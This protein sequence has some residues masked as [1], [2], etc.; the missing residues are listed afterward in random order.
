MSYVL[1]DGKEV[2]AYPLDR[3]AVRALNPA[4]SLPASLSDEMLTGFGMFLVSEATPPQITAAQALR[5]IAPIKTKD[6][7]QQQWTIDDLSADQ[8]AAKLAAAKA[9][10]W[11]QV[12][13]ERAKAIEAGCTFPGIGVFQ[14]DAAS[15]ASLTEGVAGALLAAVTSQPFTV[16]WTLADN[17]IAKLNGQQMLL[18]GKVI[19]ERKSACHARSHALR[20]EIETSKDFASLMAIKVKDGWPA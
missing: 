17:T 11:D 12:K 3:E 10:V 8:V 13:A 1:T 4:Y 6:G 9:E 5:E 14:T 18:V 16:D 20:V 19:G 7:W 15:M 2:I